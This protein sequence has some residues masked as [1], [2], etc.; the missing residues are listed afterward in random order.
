MSAYRLVCLFVYLFIPRT[1]HFVFFN[2]LFFF[3]VLS[4]HLGFNRNI[5]SL[6][7]TENREI[8]S[9]YTACDDFVCLLYLVWFVKMI[10]LHA[11]KVKLNPK[12]NR[13]D[14]A[15]QYRSSCFCISLFCHGSTFNIFTL[16]R[17]YHVN[18]LLR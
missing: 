4:S 5:L 8:C 13:T 10:R 2:T 17:A 16:A 11:L 3:D 7:E 15:L 18:F 14:N 12:L 9:E 6:F 1:Y